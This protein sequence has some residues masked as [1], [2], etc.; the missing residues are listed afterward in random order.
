M[1]IRFDIFCLNQLSNVS[2]HCFHISYLF[3]LIGRSNQLIKK[4]IIKIIDL[5]IANK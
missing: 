4:Q 3:H 2:D 5:I 1:K